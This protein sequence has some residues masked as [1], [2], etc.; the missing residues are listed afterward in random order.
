MHVGA[1]THDGRKIQTARRRRVLVDDLS[2][3]DEPCLG[4]SPD[5]VNK[6]QLADEIIAKQSIY[7]RGHRDEQSAWTSH[8]ILESHVRH[9]VIAVRNGNSDPLR[10]FV[11]ELLN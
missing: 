4:M 3:H 8:L 10:D 9:R 6:P 1:R 5:F 7:G 11:I 2:I